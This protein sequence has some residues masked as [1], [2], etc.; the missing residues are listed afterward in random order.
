MQYF[1]DIL[2]IFL[3]FFLHFCQHF[4][5]MYV[6]LNIQ[7]QFKKKLK[8]ISTGFILEYENIGSVL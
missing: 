6:F 8:Q 1:Q 2:T 7:R 4:K 5:I 3:I